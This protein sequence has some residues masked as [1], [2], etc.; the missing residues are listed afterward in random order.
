MG[1]TG[2]D[3]LPVVSRANLHELEGVVGLL[4]VLRAFGVRERRPPDSS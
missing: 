1:E 3:V 4:D 2:F